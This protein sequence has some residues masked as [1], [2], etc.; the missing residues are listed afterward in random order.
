M[1]EDNAISAYNVLKKHYDELGNYSEEQ[2]RHLAVVLMNIN[3]N[4]A[5]GNKTAMT[6]NKS[7]KE[8]GLGVLSV[9]QN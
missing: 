1:E 5:K 2:I 4:A 8:H 3:E 9:C 6:L 7:I